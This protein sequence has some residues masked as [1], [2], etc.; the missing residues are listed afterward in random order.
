MRHGE[1][2]NPEGIL[3]G[4]LPGYRLSELGRQMADRV[5]EDLAGR[6][7]THVVASPLERAQ[8]TAEP[9]AKSHGLDLA[10]DERL[11]EAD[12]IFQGKTFGVGDGSLKNPGYWKY[13]TNPFKPSWGEPYIEQAVRMM[14]ALAAARDAARGHEAVCVS[15]QL[16]IWIVRSFVERRRLWH[17]PRNRQ[18]SLASL[19]S[20]TYEGDKIVSVG[21]RE[22]ARDLLPAHL[23]GKGGKSKPVGKSFGA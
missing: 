5:A 23:V 11:I 6:D 8:E 9:I 12:N 20:F 10:V 3:Y 15:H 7:I 19:T 17:D 16:P 18:C 14:G 2:H 22:P 1:V 21:Y 13:L 4:R